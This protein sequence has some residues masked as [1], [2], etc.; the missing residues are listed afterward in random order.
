MVWRCDFDNDCSD[1]L[2]ERDCNKTTCAPNFRQCDNGQ[3]ISSKWWCDLEKDCQVNHL[4]KLFPGCLHTCMII[5]KT[6]LMINI[7]IRMDLMN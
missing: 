2:D 4:I 6:N 5:K 1:G 7:L 3:C